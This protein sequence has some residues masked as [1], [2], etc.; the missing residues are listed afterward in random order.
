MDSV[1]VVNDAVHGMMELPGYVRAAMMTSLFQRLR[2]VKQVGNLHYPWPGATHTRY[3][4]S[5]G[6][7]Y[8]ALKYAQHLQ[9]DADRTRVFVLASLLHDIAHGPF[10]HTFELASREFDHD[11]FRFRLLCEDPELQLLLRDDLAAIFRVWRGEDRV[12]HTL[13][14]GVAGVDRMDYLLRDLYHTRPQMGLDASCVQSI[15]LHTRVDW[16]R[17]VVQYTTDGCRFISHLLYMRSYLYREVYSHRKA[18]AADYAIQQAF[19][20]GLWQHIAPL[21]TPTQFVKLDDATITAAAYDERVP[22]EARRWLRK[23]LNE[24]QLPVLVDVPDGAPAPGD[25][26][27]DKAAFAP[28]ACSLDTVSTVRHEHIALYFKDVPCVHVHRRPLSTLANMVHL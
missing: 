22:G 10:S 6:T 21:L 16:D 18:M 15:I 9:M 25:V 7:A 26:I 19:A 14:A 20:A 13:L 28:S 1:K 11:T 3:A 24:Q 2:R 17:Q 8:L 27:L 12:L 5:C 4:H 23:A